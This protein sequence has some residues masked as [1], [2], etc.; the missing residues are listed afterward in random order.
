MLFLIFFYRKPTLKI[1]Q[2]NEDIVY[3]P[4]YGTIMDITYNKDNTIRIP[5]FLSPFD[6]HYQIYPISGILT[7]ILYDNTGKYELAYKVNKSNKNEKAIHTIL[8]KHGEFKIFQIAGTLVRRIS[9]FNKPITKINTGEFLGMIHF[10][11]RVDIIIPNANRFNL[12]VKKG[13]KVS[14]IETILGYY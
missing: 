3:S 10:G 5:I 12:S 14:G 13:D 8:N 4:G 9:Y 6:I 1:I 7:N 2:Y 11:S